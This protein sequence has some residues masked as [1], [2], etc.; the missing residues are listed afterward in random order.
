MAEENDLIVSGSPSSNGECLMPRI[1][2][3]SSVNH[4][5]HA[6]N[7]GNGKA[8]VIQKD[9]THAVFL[10]L[11]DATKARHPVKIFD[12]WLR[13]S[14]SHLVVQSAIKATLSPFVQWW[15]TSHV[16]HYHR[17][18]HSL[19]HVWQGRFKSL[20]IQQDD[21]LLTVLR[22]ILLNPVRAKFVDH[23]GE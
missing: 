14:H 17:N 11:L 13:P 5:Y 20:P 6:L 16:R 23:A 4:A 19:L 1:P 8:A 10:N 18:Y 3:G 12:F 9:A 2:R 21:H 15:M 7:R 22:D